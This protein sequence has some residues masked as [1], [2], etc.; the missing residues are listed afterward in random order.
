MAEV[1]EVE[2]LVLR[3]VLVEVVRSLEA[4]D[5]TDTF[6]VVIQVGFFVIAVEGIRFVTAKDNT[7]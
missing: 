1:E 5:G 4:L 3:Q 6:E 7:D 2:E